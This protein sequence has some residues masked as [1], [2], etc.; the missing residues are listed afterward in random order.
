M[1]SD[2]AVDIGD[3]RHFPNPGKRAYGVRNKIIC[4]VAKEESE[5]LGLKIK[6]SFA[7]D[8]LE[9]YRRFLKWLDA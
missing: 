6:P 2:I 4:D 3:Q 8:C 9:K 5:R 7:E 1:L